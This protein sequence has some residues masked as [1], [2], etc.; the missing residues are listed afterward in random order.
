[1]TSPS[2]VRKKRIGAG[3]SDPC[4][5]SSDYNCNRTMK[6]TDSSSQAPQNDNEKRND[7]G[8]PS[9]IAIVSRETSRLPPHIVPFHA[10]LNLCRK[11]AGFILRMFQLHEH[12]PREVDSMFRSSDLQSAKAREESEPVFD[13][14]QRVLSIPA[15]RSH[16]KKRK[17]RTSPHPGEDFLL[18][19]RADPLCSS[20]RMRG[21][22]QI[23][24]SFRYSAPCSAI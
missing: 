16:P 22:S 21:S 14:E 17:F 2:S 13:T 9:E 23:S 3:L 18:R 1:M 5:E 4:R 12:R 8:Q 6:R 10:R 11:A 24:A 7:G 15:K 19:R 20:R